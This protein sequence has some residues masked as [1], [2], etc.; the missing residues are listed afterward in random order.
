[1]TF[2]TS[3]FEE[4]GAKRRRLRRALGDWRASLVEALTVGGM[5]FGLF[6]PIA[7]PRGETELWHG[8]LAPLG[9]AAGLAL[10][11]ARRR[12]A[13]ARGVDEARLRRGYDVLTLCLMA[14]M[15]LAG[16]A[17]YALSAATVPAA[18]TITVPDTVPEDAVI[19]DLP[20]GGL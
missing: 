14:A 4:L 11:E 16:V 6:G 13:L 1:M 3:L 19:I 12:G 5:G 20:P 15:A 8:L 2:F 7:Y 9:L 10:L 18:P 17:L